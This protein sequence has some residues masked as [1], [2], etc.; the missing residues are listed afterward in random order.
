MK[1]KIKL[2]ISTFIFILFFII[3]YKSLNKTN[4]YNPKVDLNN[5]IPTYSSRIFNSEK[6]FDY[7]D[8]FKTQSFYLLNIWSSWCIPCRDEHHL[9]MNLSKNDKIIMIGLNYKDNINNAQNF[10]NELGNPFNK[11]LID[12]D[13]VQAI[14]WGAVGVPETLLIYN[15]RVIKKY[16]GPLNKKLLN[17][18]ISLLE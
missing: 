9:L 6:I 10:L 2:T 18:I 4:I 15:N 12:I 17:E 1:N 11:I 3:F 7:G 14:E 16:I 13:G 5:K 8:I